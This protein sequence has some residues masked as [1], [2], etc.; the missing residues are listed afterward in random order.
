M[1][2]FDDME[3]SEKIRIIDKGIDQ[4]E[5]YESFQDAISERIGDI[6][7]PPAALGEPLKIEVAHFL[8]CVTNRKKPR[9]DAESGIRVLEVLEAIETSIK[10]GGASVEIV[11]P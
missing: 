6:R 7:I 1:A 3:P 10:S 2:V 5:Y 9:T 4:R 11:S 8:E